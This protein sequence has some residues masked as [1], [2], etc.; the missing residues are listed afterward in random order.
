MEVDA[1]VLDLRPLVDD[2]EDE[3]AEDEHGEAELQG[4]AYPA[5][6][7]RAGA[8]PRAGLTDPVQKWLAPLHVS[9]HLSDEA[10]AD[11]RRRPRP[12]SLGRF[13][14]VSRW[15]SSSCL[16]KVRERLPPPGPRVR[17]GSGDDAAVTVPGGA[18]AT[19]VDALV[20]G[21]HFRRERATLT[22]IGRKAL[23]AALSDLAAM[24][25]EPGEAY[26]AVGIPTDLDEG[27]CL[28]LIDGIAA[29]AAATGTTLAGGDVSRAPALTLAVTVVGHADGRRAAGRPRRRQARRRAGPDRGD[30]RRR[31]GPAAAGAPRPRRGGRPSEPPRTCGGASSTRRPGS[32]PDGR[33][34]QP[35]PGR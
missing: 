21:V 34:R 18:T 10:S 22:Q 7:R 6:A 1:F 9:A 2:G 16:A 5:A 33:W 27:G 11:R 35:A 17:V 13:G 25:A 12:A 4:E 31:R 29:V 26:V 28:E 8:E 24:G 30:R 23:A 32:P 14:I 15:A 3:E 19:S 20:D